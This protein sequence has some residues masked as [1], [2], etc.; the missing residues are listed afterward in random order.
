M[1]SFNSADVVGIELEMYLEIC[2]G[3]G[4]EPYG[5]D[6]DDEIEWAMDV[7]NC[8]DITSL[9]NKLFYDKSYSHNDDDEWNY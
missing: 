4:F 2:D 3:Y 8:S 6:A 1:E 7:H 5:L 9:Y